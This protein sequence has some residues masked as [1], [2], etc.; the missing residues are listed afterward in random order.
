MAT[1]KATKELWSLTVACH[2]NLP[3][4]DV[5]VSGCGVGCG[6]YEDHH[7]SYLLT[8][9]AKVFHLKAYIAMHKFDVICITK[10]CLDR[11]TQSD[12]SNL[13]ISRYN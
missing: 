11:N 10:T 8:I 1:R 3:C 9:L 4:N 12:D 7:Q 6:L 2:G 5:M 13:E